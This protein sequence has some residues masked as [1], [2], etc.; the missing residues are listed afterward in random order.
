MQC[1]DNSRLRIPLPEVCDTPD[2]GCVPI[3]SEKPD[4][5]PQPD[6]IP[7]AFDPSTSTLWIFSCKTREWIAFRKF[8]LCGD[9]PEINISNLAEICELLRIPVFFDA[10]AGCQEGWITLQELVNQIMKCLRLKWRAV[11]VRSDTLKIDIANLEDVLPPWYVRFENLQPVCGTGDEGDPIVVKGADPICK[12]PVKSFQDVRDAQVKHL[13]ACLDDEMSRVPFPPSPCEFERTTQ[14]QVENASEK[15]VI[16]C[17]DDENVKIPVPPGFF[18]P[19]PCGFPRIENSQVKSASEKDIIMCVD[20]ENVK[21]PVP[22]SFF[23]IPP[24]EYPQVEQA[25]VES[26]SERNIIMCLDGEHVKTPLPPGFYSRSPCEYPQYTRAQV[27]AAQDKDIILCVDGKHAKV[28]V[29]PGFFI[30]E[31]LCVPEVTDK[32]ESPPP[33]GTGPI[34]V[35]CN[36]RI[37]FWICDSQI[38]LT[39]NAGIA[40]VD[41]LASIEKQIENPCDDVA[42][43]AWVTK[44]GDVCKTEASLTM[45]ELAERMFECLE[46][47]EQDCDFGSR[48]NRWLMRS[49][50][51]EAISGSG[52]GGNFDYKP[53]N[54]GDFCVSSRDGAV[55]MGEAQLKGKIPAGSPWVEMRNTS[56]IPR[57]YIIF[58]KMRAKRSMHSRNNY[59]IGLLGIMSFDKGEAQYKHDVATS[60]Y[61]IFKEMTVSEG[62]TKSCAKR[63]EEGF[64]LEGLPLCAGTQ[65]FQPRMYHGLVNGYISAAF[66]PAGQGKNGYSMQRDG[67]QQVNDVVRTVNYTF[68]TVPPGAMR[69]ATFDVIYSL[70]D[71]ATDNEIHFNCTNHIGA[72]SVNTRVEAEDTED[73]ADDD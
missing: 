60:P 37:H 34:R 66:L 35:D 1:Q 54:R 56:C 42:F 40:G 13:G 50:G 39:V 52:T 3:V 2:I 14:P 10:G 71:I 69:R 46:S 9:L 65:Q 4:C 43:K 53:V 11:C 73:S 45:K 22:P 7:F 41:R 47:D 36:G 23:M 48:F 67:T 5:E 21:T 17:V 20:D 19:P 51:A 63:L 62:Q 16:L 29:P 12:W 15:D 18:T 32:P 49:V 38:W 30:P 28:P 64:S 70:S 58:T 55:I 44:K 8:R 26:A 24:C 6:Q 25:R 33:E 61:G 72:F 27:D 57:T 68:M 59:S 31:Y